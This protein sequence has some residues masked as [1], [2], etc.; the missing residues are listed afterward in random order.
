MGRA[1]SNRSEV[2]IGQFP[3]NSVAQRDLGLLPGFSI[4][5]IRDLLDGRERAGLV[6]PCQRDQVASDQP[7]RAMVGTGGPQLES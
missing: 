7:Q 2:V 3:S 4:H 6:T 5:T 1:N